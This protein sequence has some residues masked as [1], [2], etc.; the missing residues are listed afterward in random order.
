MKKIYLVPNANKDKEL[1]ITEAVAEKLR[2][3]GAE[4][5]LPLE[6]S[7][8]ISDCTFT[9]E[10]NL[11]TELVIV[12]GGDGSFIDASH[13]AILLNAPILGINL[14]KL[15]YLSEVETDDLS[16]LDSIFTGNYKIVEK[17]LLDC[18]CISEGHEIRSER[19]AVNDVVVSHSSYLGIADFTVRSRD[20]CVG[21]RA[22]GLVISTPAGSTA[23]SLSVGGPVVSHSAESLIVTPIAP[24]S[25]FNRSLIFGSRETISVEC[26]SDAELNVSVDGR[27]FF[28]LSKGDICTVFSSCKRLKVLTF[29]NNNML[30]VL[31]NKMRTV[32]DI[33]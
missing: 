33:I 16:A 25:F 4:I 24:H 14:G 9:D 8:K 17:M 19:L 3:C 32:E 27:H 6:F 5:T 26:T 1:K 15:G 7:G 10:P 30:S 12:I 2:S 18:V 23:Y 31:F 20:G 21:Y 13:F 11:D 29:T 28:T 22:D